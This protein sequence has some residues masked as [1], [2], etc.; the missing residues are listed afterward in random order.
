MSSTFEEILA[1]VLRRRG[2]D[3]GGYREGTLRRRLDAR[4]A[5]IGT[6]GLAPYLARLEADPDECDRL[7]DALAVNVS[8]FFRDPLVFDVLARRVLPDIVDRAR[9]DGRRGV[10]VWCAGCAGGEEPYSIAMLLCEELGA[11]LGDWT[12]L[13]VA[14][15]IDRTALARAHA[16]TYPRASL[17]DTRLGLVDRYFEPAGNAFRVA[18]AVRDLVEFSEDDVTSPHLAA[19]AAS[20]FGSFDLVLCRNLLIYLRPDRR[21]RVLRKLL[22][23]VSP[24]G[25]VSLG[26]SE[27]PPAALE[28][29]MTAVFPGAHIFRVDR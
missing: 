2:I 3:L 15:D 7:I 9:S 26:E 14:T 22:G 19:P 17:A 13:V 27:A 5:Q 24:G 6:D 10:R 20:V 1:V 25:Y 16:G 21:D 23:A 18:Q 12:C 4:M 29:T 11:E 28:S 8:A